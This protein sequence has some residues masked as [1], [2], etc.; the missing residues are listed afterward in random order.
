M[1]SEL[2]N[3]DVL[4]S[5]ELSHFLLNVW[6]LQDHQEI[7]N[8]KRVHFG[9]PAI[10]AFIIN[11]NLYYDPSIGFYQTYLK[12]AV[13][14][15]NPLLNKLIERKI[16][17]KLPI[18]DEDYESIFQ[19]SI[20]DTIEFVSNNI[21]ENPKK[22][23]YYNYF[24]LLESPLSLFVKESD[25]F[26]QPIWNASQKIKKAQNYLRGIV[27][28]I[29]SSFLS[30][31]IFKV[32]GIP[33]LTSRLALPFLEEITTESLITAIP[34]KH[35]QIREM[36]DA[37][38]KERNSVFITPKTINIPDFTAICQFGTK[39]NKEL[40]ENAIEIREN[41]YCKDFR[42]VLWEVFNNFRDDPLNS[43]NEIILEKYRETMDEL[44]VSI[45]KSIKS[46]IKKTTLNL[47]ITSSISV[48]LDP[49]S[50]LIASMGV[51]SLQESLDVKSIRKKHGW[52][53]LIYNN[54]KLPKEDV[55]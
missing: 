29:F 4:L 6:F 9:L 27:P 45:D 14:Q 35:A 44:I 16:I 22:R 46:R 13:F 18:N 15:E 33:F 10:E 50:S 30:I 20:Q 52:F 12:K 41:Q 32:T 47:L 26:L 8:A 25:L 11:E 19:Q 21:L 49:L 34:S 7:D 55:Y 37:L 3:K 53:F 1:V 23:R 17:R 24:H 54:M 42:E 2:Q 39:N 38:I 31:N 51:S 36:I 48:F 40:L 5:R 43:P 28:F